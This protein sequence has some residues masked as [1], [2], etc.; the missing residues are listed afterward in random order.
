MSGERVTTPTKNGEKA[1][2]SVEEQKELAKQKALAKQQAKAAKAAQMAEK[3]AGK[4]KEADGP[5]LIGITAKKLEDLPSW[6]NQVLTKGEML[7]YYD[8]SGCY[9]LRP[10]AY[11]VWKELQKYFGAEI[12]KMGVEDVYFPMFVSQKVL[13]KEKDHI[14]GFSPEV[15]WVTKAGSSNLQEPIAIR[16]TSETVMYPYFST[17]IRSHRDLPLKL[18]QWCNVV[19]WEFKHPQPFLRTREFLWQEGHTAHETKEEADKEVREILELYASV[20]EK[21]L[22]VPVIR[23]QKSEKEKFAGGLYTT[24]VEAF[25]PASGRAIQGGTSHCLGTNFAKMFDIQVETGPGK[26]SYVWQNSW[27][28]T[29]R[30]IGVMVMVHGDD[31][32]LVMPPRVAAIQVVVVPCGITAKTLPEN[33]KLIYDKC[34]EISK[35]L[36]A[37]GLR[38]K[39]DVRDN[40]SP[41]NKFYHWE[42]KGVPIR[43]EVGP[44]DIENKEVRVVR[45][46]SGEK[47]QFKLENLEETIKEELERIQSAMYENAKKERDSKVVHLKKFDSDFVKALDNKCLVLA[48]WCEIT[49]CENF[50]KAESARIAAEQ[51]V[52]DKAPSMGAKTLCIP[53]DQPTD[54]HIKEGKCCF[55]CDKKAVRWT[56]WGRSY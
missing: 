7:D 27:G 5:A 22:A 16:P 14:E 4:K 39:A 49:E 17:W 29:T 1:A 3:Q 41:G 8:V 30:T 13:E 45:R 52:D 25:I 40:V 36:E 2:L 55:A 10:Y 9:I 19:R 37:S 48:P 21:L 24:T 28:L 15:A 46:F 12:E 31:K 6:Y 50:V 51:Q 53:F 18:N 47:S 20:Y 42:L 32:G 33:A 54:S 34:A 26:K 11:K 43:L 35:T 44:K 56:L 38:T 23:G